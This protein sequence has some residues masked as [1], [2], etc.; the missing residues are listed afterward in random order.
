MPGFLAMLLGRRK[1]GIGAAVLF[2]ASTPGAAVE[3]ICLQLAEKA[4][5]E[6]AS[7][8]EPWRPEDEPPPEIAELLG[9]WW[10][11]GT[12][13]VFWWE[14]GKLRAR[15]Q[16]NDTERLISVFVREDDGDFRV[17]EGRERGERLRVVRGADGSIEKLYWATYPVMRRPTAFGS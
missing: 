8:P 3:S 11:E 16:E 15:P 2:N 5:E 14:G 12:P 7:E 10:E 9:V 13:F 1:E 6:Y 4:L 17:A